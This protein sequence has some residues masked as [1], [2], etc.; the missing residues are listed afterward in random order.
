MPRH[1]IAG[2]TV[3]INSGAEK[4]KTGTI[5]RVIPKRNMVVVQGANMH[6]KHLKPS[7]AAPQGGVITKE[8]P[9]HMCKVNPVVDGKPTRVRFVTKD[10]GSKVRVASRNGKELS[11]LHKGRKSSK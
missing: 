6:T 7:Q 9:L 1:I 8:M 3:M 11:V 5:I 10:D 4:G 2:D